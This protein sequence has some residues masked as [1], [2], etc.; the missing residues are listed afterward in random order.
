MIFFKKGNFSCLIQRKKNEP[1]DVFMDRSNFIVSQRPIDN[2]DL[3]KILIFS[4]IYANVKYLNCSY[5][6]SIMNE[7][8][9]MIENCW[10]D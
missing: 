7:L 6:G 8:D 3:T 9:K 2:K 5:E 1:I 4:N 10:V